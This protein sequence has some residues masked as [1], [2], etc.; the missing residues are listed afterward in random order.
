VDAPLLVHVGSF[1]PNALLDEMLDFFAVYRERQP[2]AHFLFVAPSGEAQVRARAAERGVG[3]AVHVRSASRE[4]VPHWLGAADT[5]IM[6]VRP[7]WSKR[8]AS[9][10]KLG[11]MLA[12]GLPVIA[13]GG[14]GDVA[15]VLERSSAGVA[16]TRFDPAAYADAI[17]RIERL[18]RSAEEIR[19]Q[20]KLW[21]DLS[22]GIRL[23]DQ[24]YDRLG[25]ASG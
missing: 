6:F 21:F 17:G 25:S 1:G 24:I 22:V 2:G 15:D 7:V 23:Y 5:G 12:V 9:P 14:V 3:D 13:N 20:G 19:G 4:D 10:T 16:V 11:E 18:G 8:A